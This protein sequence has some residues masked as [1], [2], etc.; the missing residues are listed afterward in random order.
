MPRRSNYRTLA[1]AFTLIEV[2]LVIVL[3]GLLAAFLWPNFEQFAHGEQLDESVSRVKSLIAMCR[4][5][6]MNESRRYRITIKPDG[7]MQLTRQKDP[8]K[9]P[10]EYVR[11]GDGWA[12]TPWLLD[13]VW[14][15]SLLALPDGPPPLNV[16]DD[17][18]E[19]A[20]IDVSPE[21]QDKPFD[22]DFEIDGSSNSVRWVMRDL[23]G[24][25]RMLTLDGRVGRVDVVDVDSIDAEQLKKPQPEKEAK[26]LEVETV[27][28]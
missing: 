21:P 17:N 18:I 25:G 7:T 13:E 11:V 4:A 23:R 28:P 2:L 3:I 19:F 6:S 20:Q 27:S 5:Q 10:E 14:V 9:A 16:Q 24:R 1:G 22:V 8:L 12:Q 15:E 26:Q